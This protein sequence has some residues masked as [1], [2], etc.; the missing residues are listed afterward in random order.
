M[1]AV[2]KKIALKKSENKLLANENVKFT[3]RVI[4]VSEK[5]PHRG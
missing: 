4:T 2:H 3:K 1:T 5:S